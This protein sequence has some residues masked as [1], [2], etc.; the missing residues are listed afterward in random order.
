MTITK[1]D[2]C[3]AE[4]ARSSEFKA[5][6]EI[7][8]GGWAVPM[9]DDPPTEPVQV[10]AEFVRNWKDGELPDLCKS[11]TGELLTLAGAELVRQADAEWQQTEALAPEP[12]SITTVTR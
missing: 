7:E 11:C 5:R 3:G 2:R 1:C 4:G 9:R 6:V 8:V 12:G 10:T